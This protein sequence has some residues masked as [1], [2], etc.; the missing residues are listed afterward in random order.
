MRGY[1][2][3]LASPARSSFVATLPH[4]YGAFEAA[5]PGTLASALGPPV[6]IAV[7]E[8]DVAVFHYAQGAVIRR[9]DS[10]TGLAAAVPRT[11]S[12]T[13]TDHGITIG[14]ELHPWNS[15]NMRSLDPTAPMGRFI[16]T[17]M[18]RDTWTTVRQ[19]TADTT[20]DSVTIRRTNLVG[21][22]K[23]QMRIEPGFGCAAIDASGHIGVSLNSG[24]F[25]LVDAEGLHDRLELRREY[26][27]YLVSA[28]AN[29][30]TLVTAE[31]NTDQSTPPVE[32]R[33]RVTGVP[34]YH[35]R[36]SWRSYVERLAADGQSRWFIELPFP[37]LQPPIDA[38]E[39]RSYAVGKGLAAI[40][41]GRISWYKPANV[42]LLATCFGDGSLA[43]ATGFM[44]RIVGRDGN[45]RQTL[46]TPDRSRILTLP[47]IGPDGTIYVGTITGVYRAR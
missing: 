34:G 29:G 44:V 33:A 5:V 3:P 46:T 8:N 18:G 28:T 4:H 47:A 9:E 6:S 16:V 20:V 45:V 14:D 7:T 22:P 15:P 1:P 25:V 30:W 26:P 38:G 32:R 21:A 23:P 10:Y 40:D 35:I 41:A 42:R 19:N 36:G 17:S 37:V 11:A 31:P 43:L 27:A 2:M 13:A 39:P 24:R 12:I